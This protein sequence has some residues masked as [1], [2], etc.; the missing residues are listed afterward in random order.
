MPMTGRYTFCPYIARKNVISTAQQMSLYFVLLCV[1]RGHAPS[2]SG[3]RTASALKHGSTH[4]AGFR[5]G[6]VVVRR[7]S[8]IA[9]VDGNRNV[10]KMSAFCP[11]PTGLFCLFFMC[12][13]NKTRAS[14]HPLP[15]RRPSKQSKHKHVSISHT[16]LAR[17][18]HHRISTRSLHRCIGIHQHKSIYP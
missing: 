9:I 5:P 4:Q 7:Q 2:G 1:Q 10:K 13:P 15:H 18:S 12:K 17:G 3:C 16:L 11:R 6:A 8:G 14:N